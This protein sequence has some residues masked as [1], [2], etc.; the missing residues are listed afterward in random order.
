[1]DDA[2]ATYDAVADELLRDADHDVDATP[3]GLLVKGRLFAFL[4]GGELV[5]DLPE[6]R[7]TDLQER[8]IVVPFHSTRGGDSRTW[9]RVA[10]LQ[11]WSELAREAHEFVGEPPVGRQS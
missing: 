5:V 6:A 8:G 11:L 2:Q 9:V 4:D 7:S 3:D 10:D 1:M